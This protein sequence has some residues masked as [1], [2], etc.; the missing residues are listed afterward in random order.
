MATVAIMHDASRESPPP[1]CTNGPFA[2]TGHMVQNPPYWM[3]RKRGILHWDIENK[4]KSSLTGWNSFVFESTTFLPSS[5]VDFVPCDQL[6]QK[7][8]YDHIFMAQ[9][10]VVPTE[11][12]CTLTIW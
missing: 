8:P 6:V 11:L 9:R 10:R 5:M 1:P 2:L 3:S 4:G 12:R 7:A